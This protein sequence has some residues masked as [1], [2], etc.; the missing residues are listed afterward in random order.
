MVFRKWCPLRDFS[1]LGS[2]SG[3]RLKIFWVWVPGTVSAYGFLEFGF[4][5]LCP[6]KDF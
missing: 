5:E 1:S 4:W 2:G 3:V 6:L